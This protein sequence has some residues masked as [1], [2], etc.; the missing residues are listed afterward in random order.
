[1][2]LLPSNIFLYRLK[3]LH[4]QAHHALY[5]WSCSVSWCLAEGHRN[6]DQHCLWDHVAREGLYF[7]MFTFCFWDVACVVSLVVHGHNAVSRI[8]PT[9]VVMTSKTRCRL[10][11]TLLT[12]TRPTV[13][14]VRKSRLLATLTVARMR[15]RQRFVTSN[16]CC[17]LCDVIQ[18]L[19]SCVVM[20]LQHPP[21]SFRSPV[22]L[23]KLWSQTT[24]QCFEFL[25][26]FDIVGLQERQLS[27]VFWNKWK[28][29]QIC[30]DNGC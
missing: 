11:S 29:A 10:S 14:C 25:W 26:C 30:L 13:G 17:R 1:M 12:P 20:A 9:S 16:S 18:S 7:F 2:A 3:L 21:V 6:G 4:K 27:S 15:T 23:K 5:L 24:G 28:N 19:L 8:K 22:K